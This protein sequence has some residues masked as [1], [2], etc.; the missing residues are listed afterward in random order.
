M[1]DESF[2]VLKR[3][4]KHLIQK[5]QDI[6]HLGVDSLNIPL[7]KICVIG[8]QSAGKSSLIEALAEIKVPRAQ[9]C[10]TRCPL[11]INLTE[12]G[13]NAPWT[14]NV[15]L[16]YKYIYMPTKTDHRAQ[17]ATKARPLGPWV[18]Q[19]PEHHD[20]VTLHSKDQVEE[21][22]RC[23]QLAIL[24]PHQPPTLYAP[25]QNRQTPETIKVKFSPN[26]I[27]LDISGP[28]LLNLSFFDLPGVIN[29]AEVEGEEYLVKL[30][31]NFVHTYVDSKDC[32]AL[33]ALPMTDDTANSSSAAII[34]SIPG[35]Q[36][37]TVGVLTKPDRVQKGDSYEQWRQMLSGEKFSIGYGYF[38]VK[39]NPNT[40]VSH[41]QAREEEEQFF[42]QEP[43]TS[44]LEDFKDRFGVRNLVGSLSQLLTGLILKKY[45]TPSDPRD[46]WKRY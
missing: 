3:G 30:V 16:S 34:K 15:I 26:V 37:R 38:V 35:A 5:I 43:W 45:V 7:P 40:R 8:A 23:A 18:Q 27:R 32:L 41:Q 6:R 1:E 10:C 22:L 46:I 19:S 42:Q 44:E 14:C 21:A 25:F 20:F 4:M 28:K 13:D 2:G 24:N 33:L 29:V 31:K 11:E 36:S 9:D 17:G 39:N 12:S